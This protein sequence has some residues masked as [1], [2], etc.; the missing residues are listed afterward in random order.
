[1]PVILL[2]LF[3]SCSSLRIFDTFT[4]SDEFDV[5]EVRLRELYD[6]VDG[7]VISESTLSHSGIAKS[8]AL[9]EAPERFAKYWDKISVVQAPLG[10]GNEDC[11]PLQ[12]FDVN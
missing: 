1:M 6:H 8:A 2:C 10:S 4:F 5:L 11:Y 3:V 7:F 9:K 12:L